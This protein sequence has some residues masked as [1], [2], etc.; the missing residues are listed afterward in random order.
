MKLKNI[1]LFEPNQTKF[2]EVCRRRQIYILNLKSRF[3]FCKCTKDTLCT[4]VKS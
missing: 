2:L 1:I 3:V 4:H